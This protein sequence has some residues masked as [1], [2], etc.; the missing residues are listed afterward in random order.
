MLTLSPQ[1]LQA[2]V[3]SLEVATTATIISTPFGIGVAYLFAC[4][5]LPGKSIIEGIVNLPLR[6][7]PVVVGYLLLLTFGR[8]G[9]LG[10][11]LEVLHVRVIYLH[12]PAQSL[13]LQL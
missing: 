4:V 3:L 11:F 8:N 13:P 1:D 7:P 9:V 2:I 5:K 12:S 10:N 6:L